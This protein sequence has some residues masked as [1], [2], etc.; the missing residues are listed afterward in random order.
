MYRR[1]VYVVTGSGIGPV[2][3]QI[4]SPRVQGR[5]VW[6]TRS[7]R[8]TYGDALVDEV[9]AAHPDAVIWDTT[10]RG[11]PDLLRVAHDVCR[12]FAAE[13]VQVV[14]NKAATWNLVHGLERLGVPAFGPIWDS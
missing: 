8:A 13:A 10:K 14:S 2:L 1:V 9:L 5:L 6:S 11:K 12:D 4:L 7:P 3:G